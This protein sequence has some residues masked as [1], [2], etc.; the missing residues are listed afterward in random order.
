MTSISNPASPG[1]PQIVTQG[2]P[3]APLDGGK[4]WGSPSQHPAVAGFANTAS[5]QIVVVDTT[6]VD[7]AGGKMNRR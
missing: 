5:T 3:T 7:C 2:T 4:P 1:Y 6:L